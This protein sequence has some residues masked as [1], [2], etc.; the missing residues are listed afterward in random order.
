M[1]DAIA[2]AVMITEFMNLGVTVVT[3]GDAIIG[4]GVLYLAVF[5]AAEF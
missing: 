4:T 1:D 3:T 2:G 5:Y